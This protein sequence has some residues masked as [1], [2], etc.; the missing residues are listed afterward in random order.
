MT[1]HSVQ[2][3]TAEATLA[4][5]FAAQQASAPSA[6][7]AAAFARFSARG[8][9]TRRVEAWHYTDLRAAMS[10]AAPL[11][12]APDQA[13]IEVARQLLVGAKATGTARLVLLNGRYVADPSDEL[14]AAIG[15]ACEELST[16]GVDDPLVA[17]NEAMSV[18]GCAVTVSDGGEIAGPIEIVHVMGRDAVCSS[19]SRVSITFGEGARASFVEVFLGAG[20]RAQRHTATTLI[21]AEDAKADH[22][23]IH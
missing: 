16:T 19:Y 12:P 14:P 22:Y 6:R 1:A 23:V 3:S 17:L 10:D 2:R 13:A 20:S 7:R 15:V 21:L 9:P 5:Q 18:R 8:L 4:R 11:A